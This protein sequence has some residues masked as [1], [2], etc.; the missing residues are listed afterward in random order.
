LVMTRSGVQF[1]LAA[2]VFF[3]DNIGIGI[4]VAENG[5]VLRPL[6]RK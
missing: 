3:N 2:P 4:N 6:A 5:R 1:S